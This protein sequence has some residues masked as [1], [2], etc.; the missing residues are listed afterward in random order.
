MPRIKRRVIS[1]ATGRKPIKPGGGQ[2]GHHA[3]PLIDRG[4]R[5]TESG[6]DRLAA[7][8]EGQDVAGLHRTALQHAVS[9]PVKGAVSAPQ[10]NA[11]SPGEL[12]DEVNLGQIV[13][14]R[15]EAMGLSQPKLAKLIGGVTTAAISEIE[16]GRTKSLSGKMQ[17]GLHRVLGI[18]LSV[19]A[20]KRIFSSSSTVYSSPGKNLQ[21]VAI[22]GTAHVEI[23]GEWRILSPPPHLGAALDFPSDDPNAYAIQIIGDAFHPRVKSGEYLVLEPGHPVS[24]GDEVLVEHVDGRSMLRELAYQRD[25]QTALNTLNGQHARSTFFDKDLLHVHYIAAIVKAS[26][27]RD[28]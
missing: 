16:R 8:V 2:L 5:N 18:P 13:K 14:E 22:L 17:E 25:G 7:A 26:R 9:E 21:R 27:Y 1:K 19:L 3:P 28:E 15:R 10:Y 20:R 23:S 12:G 11:G 24:P 6:G 4:P